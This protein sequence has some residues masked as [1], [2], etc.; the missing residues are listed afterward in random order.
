MITFDVYSGDYTGISS[1]TKP[2]DVPNATKFY[3]MYTRTMYM[4]DAESTEW[5]AQ[6]QFPEVEDG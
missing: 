4:F 6:F 2:T 1:D 3:E 5:Y